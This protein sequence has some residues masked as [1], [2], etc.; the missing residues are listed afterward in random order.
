MGSDGVE[1]NR[2]PPTLS[3][4]L[5]H[6]CL[7]TDT[8]CPD[9]FAECPASLL[10]CQGQCGRQGPQG[11]SCQEELSAVS[12]SIYLSI[13]LYIFSLCVY[14]SPSMSQHVSTYGDE[15][16][17]RRCLVLSTCCVDFV[18]VCVAGQSCDGACGG[19]APEGCFCDL[20]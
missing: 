16:V 2:G 5:L 9:F 1:R 17:S 19:Q 14:P 15:R 3:L 11:C 8:C 10:S 20:M 4:C 18:E 13:Y 6:S 12:T 7:I